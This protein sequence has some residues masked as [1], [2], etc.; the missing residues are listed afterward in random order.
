MAKLFIIAILLLIFASMGSALVFMLRDKGRSRRTVKA[1]SWR[2]GLSVLAFLLLWIAYAA[3]WIQPHGIISVSHDVE[4]GY[5]ANKEY[6]W[7]F[8]D[9]KFIRGNKISRVK[10]DLNKLINVVNR[11][12]QDPET[13]RTPEDKPP[14]DPPCIKLLKIAD[15]KLKIEVI[16]D[17]YLTQSM[18]TTG[19]Y[20]FL[21]RAT[22]ILTEYKNIHSIDFVFIEGD[23]A[24]PGI[25]KRSDFLDGHQIIGD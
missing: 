18:G 25:Y 16:N 21:A 2:I 24:R 3:G 5:Y 4:P 15:N 13:F 23:H 1:L 14:L 19:A 8:N 11:T 22:Y 20:Q 7:Y 10:N 9:D 6:S 12:D 17:D